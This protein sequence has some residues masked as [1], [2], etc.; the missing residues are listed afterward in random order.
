MIKE[1]ALDRLDTAIN[2]LLEESRAAEAALI[3]EAEKQKQ[4]TPV[5]GHVT[6]DASEDILVSEITPVAN[7]EEIS[8]SQ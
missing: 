6:N 5:I 4:I 3:A 1:G 2:R 8:T 7:D